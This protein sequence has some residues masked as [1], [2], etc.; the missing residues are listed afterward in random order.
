MADA[1]QLLGNR[2]RDLREGLQKPSLRRIVE[3]DI[4]LTAQWMGVLSQEA[5][6]ISGEA[7]DAYSM[8]YEIYYRIESSGDDGD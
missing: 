3:R 4:E 1:G 6:S 5:E 8:I 7:F 2:I